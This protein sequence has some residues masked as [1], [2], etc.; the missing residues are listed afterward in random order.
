MKTFVKTLIQPEEPNS[1]AKL[2]GYSV[3]FVAKNWGFIWR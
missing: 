1:G 2:M 3:N